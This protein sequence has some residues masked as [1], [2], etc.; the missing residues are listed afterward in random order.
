MFFSVNILLKSFCKCWFTSSPPYLSISI[1]IPS[2]LRLFYFSVS[3]WLC[4]FRSCSSYSLASIGILFSSRF[5][6][7]AGSF[8]LIAYCLPYPLL[9]SLHIFLHRRCEV[10]PM[11]FFYFL[12]DSVSDFGIF[13]SFFL[14][15]SQLDLF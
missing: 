4:L 5:S 2:D 9:G 13:F 8:L 3:L 7:F 6:I 12:V 10:F 1:G 14:G 15:S 11:F